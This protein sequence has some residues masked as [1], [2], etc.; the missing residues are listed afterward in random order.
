[1]DQQ[2]PLILDEGEDGGYFCFKKNGQD[3]P[4]SRI[5]PESCDQVNLF[6]Q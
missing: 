3:N 1:M 6:N 2:Q 4:S 5:T